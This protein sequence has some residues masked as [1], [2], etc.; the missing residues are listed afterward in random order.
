MH[1]VTSEVCGMIKEMEKI[2]SGEWRLY[3]SSVLTEA[4]VVQ[5]RKKKKIEEE[6]SAAAVAAAASESRKKFHEG[7]GWDWN[8]ILK[9][10]LCSL[11]GAD[12]T[13]VYLSVHL[14]E[15]S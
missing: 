4:D 13:T 12:G 5:E 7:T 11:T 9:S 14:K 3:L 1:W 6:N 10:I 15:G 8:L 2:T